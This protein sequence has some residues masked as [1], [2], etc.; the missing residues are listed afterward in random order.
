MSKVV[1]YAS[2]KRLGS[3]E[4][5]GPRIAAL[6]GPRF[7]CKSRSFRVTDGPTWNLEHN[8]RC[9]RATGSL[10]TFTRCFLFSR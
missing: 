5:F 3:P 9:Y 4:T 10:S 1:A 6:R 7:L 8:A 2:P